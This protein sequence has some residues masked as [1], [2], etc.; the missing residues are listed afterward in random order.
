M[1]EVFVEQPLASP[2]SAKYH[3]PS[4]TAAAFLL[5][6]APVPARVLAASPAPNPGKSEPPG[7]AVWVLIPVE[8]SRRLEEDRDPWQTG[9]A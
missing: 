3:L 5:G 1:M 4:C 6:T 8:E 7:T 2:G 9:T